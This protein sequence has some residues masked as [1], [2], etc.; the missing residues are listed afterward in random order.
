MSDG[1]DGDR[2]NAGDG[3]KRRRSITEDLKEEA[4]KMLLDGHSAASVAHRLG[5]SRPSLVYSGSGS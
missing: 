2:S 3:E 5:L 4:V 1:N